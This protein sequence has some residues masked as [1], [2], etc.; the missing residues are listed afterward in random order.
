MVRK[1]IKWTPEW[2]EDSA[3]WSAKFIRKNKWRLD[4]TLSHED[5]MQDAVVIFYY[6]A[7]SYPRVVNPAKFMA[8]FKRA[9]VNKTHDRSLYGTRKR[10]A[11]IVLEKDVSEYFHGSIGELSNEGYLAALLSEAPVEVQLALAGLANGVAAEPKTTKKRKPLQP[12]ENLSM[13]L[14]RLLGLSG[15]D[16]M[17]YLKQILS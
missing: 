15:M 10:A 17:K 6:V 7:A 5:L 3:K 8:L 13:R 12:R 4:P 16:T 1:R 11:E 14:S 2:N 9:M